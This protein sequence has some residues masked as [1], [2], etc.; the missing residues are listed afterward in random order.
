MEPCRQDRKTSRWRVPGYFQTTRFRWQNRTT[1]RCSVRSKCTKGTILTTKRRMSWTRSSNPSER[2]ATTPRGGTTI[3]IS[4]TAVWNKSRSS[5]RKWF[6]WS[7]RKVRPR[8]S[9]TSTMRR[10]IRGARW[11]KSAILR[12]SRALWTNSNRSRTSTPPGWGQ[13][14][15]RKMRRTSPRW[16]QKTTSNSKSTRS[17][18]K[19]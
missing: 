12:T 11:V 19:V 9:R 7:S 3:S 8:C 17:C 1:I 14:S 13:W 10:G 5:P 4:T 16:L 15:K 18:P 2:T 6:R